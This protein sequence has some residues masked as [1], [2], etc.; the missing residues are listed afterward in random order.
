MGNIFLPQMT[1]PECKTQYNLLEPRAP[2]NISNLACGDGTNPVE[3][4]QCSSST[5]VAEDFLETGNCCTVIL[6]SR[7]THQ[8]CTKNEDCQVGRCELRLGGSPG[9]YAYKTC[10]KSAVASTQQIPPGWTPGGIDW[11]TYTGDTSDMGTGTS[12]GSPSNQFM[13]YPNSRGD[14]F[15]GDNQCD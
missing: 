10:T 5:C 2:C 3:G 7:T 1:Q 12:H 8:S 9:C 15:I 11:A 6:G 13:S 14:P 4:A